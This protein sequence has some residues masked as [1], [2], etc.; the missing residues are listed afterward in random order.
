MS[1]SFK[2]RA[3]FLA[4]ASIFALALAACNSGNGG[5]DEQIPVI[6]G[7]PQD[8]TVLIGAGASFTVVST[9]A[10]AYTWV[11]NNNDTL[12][13][14]TATLVLDSLGLSDSGDTFKVIVKSATGKTAVSRNAL[15]TVV[16]SI[17]PPPAPGSRQALI[18]TGMVLVQG[19]CTGC[20]GSELRGNAGSIPPLANSDFFMAD[21]RRVAGIL[22]NGREDSIFVNG[23]WYQGTMPSFNFFTDYEIAGILTYI[24]AVLNDSTVVSCNSSTLDDN[25]FAICQ[26]TERTPSEVAADSVP[27]S[28][29]TAVR[30]SLA[31]IAPAGKKGIRH[32]R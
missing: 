18:D 28:L 21:R 4:L 25:G 5:G 15:L 29:V 12:T 13:A 24:R 3:S 10:A 16:S 1:K 14:T 8:T 17:T 23:Q 9:N 32:P 31:L 20:H 2:N 26:K 6:T 22:I 11:R 27:V 7:Q 30:D 19:N